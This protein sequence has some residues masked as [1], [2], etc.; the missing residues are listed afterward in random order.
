M[1]AIPRWARLLRKRGPCAPRRLV[2]ECHERASEPLLK[3]YSTRRRIGIPTKLAKKNNVIAEISQ[4][5]DDA[6]CGG[7]ARDDAA[8]VPGSASAACHGVAL[9]PG[10]A[11][12]FRDDAGSVS[13]SASAASV[14]SWLGLRERQRVPPPSA[15][16]ASPGLALLLTQARWLADCAGALPKPARK[17]G[18]FA[19]TLAKPAGKLG[20]NRWCFSEAN[21]EEWARPLDLTD[22]LSVW[23]EAANST[24]SDDL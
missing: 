16:G 24:S 23:H 3:P 10:S 7:A 17:L 18:K 6:A 14:L 19:G 22:A 5:Y 2:V 1:P 13:G 15:M 12:A 11:S 9:V 20:Q 4:E 21:E 8:L